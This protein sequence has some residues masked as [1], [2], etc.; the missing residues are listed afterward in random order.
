M[1]WDAVDSNWCPFFDDAQARIVGPMSLDQRI[2][3]TSQVSEQAKQLSFLPIEHLRTL[4][5]VDVTL[6]HT[7][8]VILDK[9]TYKNDIP[10][11]SRINRL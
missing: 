4:A 1:W 2:W 6:I 8:L 11:K 5:G 9:D 7:K 10:F 3:L